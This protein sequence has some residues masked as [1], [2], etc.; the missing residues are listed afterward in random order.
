TPL[1]RASALAIFTLACLACAEPAPEPAREPAPA[2]VTVGADRLFGEYAHLIRGKRL[3]LVANHSTRLADG[4]HLADALHAWPD[5]ALRVLF[6][7]EFD[8]RSNDYSAPRDPESTVDAA[9]GLPKHSLYGEIH[10]PT[11]EMLDSVE[12]IVFDIQE[13]GARFYEHVNILGFVMEAASELGIE[14]VVLDRPNPIT[15]LNADGFVTDSAAL[16]RFGSYAPIPVVHGMTV[17]ELAQMYNGESMLR[18]GK[19]VTLHVVPMKGWTRDLWYDETGLEWRKPSPNLLTLESLT[20][21]VGTCLFE[22]LNVSEGRGTETPFEI[23]G[24]PWLDAAAAAELLNG[25]G[26]AGVRF[27]AESFTPEQMPYHG[28]P[29]EMAGELLQGVRLRVTD[30]DA[31]QP[32]RAGVALLWAVHKL[33]PDELVWDDA[34]LDRLAATPR[35]KKMLLAGAEPAAIFAAWKDEVE[36]FRARNAPYL[37]YE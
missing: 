12:V 22:A 18:G 1:S 32:Y 17:G 35:L 28:R 34:V 7:M 31:F 6:G 20:A 4:T 23:V 25:L 2:P 37:I 13:V 10:K 29:P 8:I 26:L 5:A 3:A 36:S 9:T 21:Y 33:H 24:A 30:R 14:V 27:E 11:P 19:A 15:G 16:F